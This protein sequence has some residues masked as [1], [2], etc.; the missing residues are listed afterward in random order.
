[1]PKEQLIRQITGLCAR[2]R[3]HDEISLILGGCLR[4][5]DLWDDLLEFARKQGMMPL[6]YKHFKTLDVS[7]PKSVR[8]KLKAAYLQTKHSNQIRSEEVA[9]ILS[10]YEQAGI[11]TFP[12]KGIALCN[13]VFDDIGSRPMRDIDL[14]VKGEDTP[15][16]ENILLDSGYQKEKR[17]DIPQGHYHLTPVWKMID[18][19]SVNIE[20][21]HNLLPFLDEYPLTPLEKFKSKAIGISIGGKEAKTL[22]NEDQLWYLYQHGFY[23]PLTYEPFRFMHVADIVS[24]IEN[25]TSDM[26]WQELK[27][28]YS[29]L[30]TALAQFH[31]ITPFSD[32]IIEAMGIKT[33]NRPTGV[34]RPYNGWPAKHLKEIAKPETPHFLFETFWPAEWWLKVY[35]RVDQ[36][37]A[38]WRARFITHP[39]LV[40]WWIRIYWPFFVDKIKRKK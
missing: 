19:L 36:G 31:W 4:D 39:G 11:E 33:N 12:V 14:L 7:L 9:R 37:I 27:R 29:D 8:V 23:S 20:L 30:M 24:L 3:I 17:H 26:N 38:Y 16:A 22:S 28:D 6:L 5:F 10:V 40:W 21:H 25:Q 34:G 18:G 13:Y 2:D 1:M 35:Y 15:L 32:K